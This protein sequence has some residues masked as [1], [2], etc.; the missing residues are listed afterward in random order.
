MRVIR[1]KRVFDRKAP[2]DGYRVLVDRKWPLGVRKEAAALSYWAKELA[3]SE[4]LREFYRHDP[5]RWTAFQARFREE[6]KAPAA[7]KTL[8]DLAAIVS[9]GGPVTLIYASREPLR[10]NAAV[11][12]EVME[13]YL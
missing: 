4:E 2:D 3:P 7:V 11:V 9:Q 8:M 10:N 12:K 13:T 6:L 1:I 5:K